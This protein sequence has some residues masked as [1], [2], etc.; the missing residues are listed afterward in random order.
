MQISQALK[1]FTSLQILH[2]NLPDPQEITNE[3]LDKL[4]SAQSGLPSLTSLG[5]LF[6]G[7]TQNFALGVKSLQS[8]VHL[9]LNL[10][11]SNVSLKQVRMLSSSLKA[12][13]SSL[14]FLEISFA[15]HTRKLFGEIKKN[16]I[17]C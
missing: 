9:R 8:L 14:K 13:Q 16:Q 12:L 5:L 10:Q 11:N 17:H 4:S 7:F 6:P 1:K 3:G 2:L 15:Q